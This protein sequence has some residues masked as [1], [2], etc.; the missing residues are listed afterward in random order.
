MSKVH[1]FTSKVGYYTNRSASRW[2]TRNTDGQIIWDVPDNPVMGVSYKGVTHGSDGHKPTAYSRSVI[3]ATGGS[4]EGSKANYGTFLKTNSFHGSG[5]AM[6][7]NPWGQYGISSGKVTPSGYLRE[8]AIVGA[9]EKMHGQNAF[10]LEDLAQSARTAK[11]VYDLAKD[12]VQKTGKYLAVLYAA[13]SFWES[14]HGPWSR[15]YTPKSAKRSNDPWLKRLANAWLA[16]YYGIKPLISTINAIGRNE[17][18]RTK[19]VKV[20][21]KRSAVLDP[22]GLF[23]QSNWG[24]YY[25]SFS[26]NAKEEVTVTLILDVSMSTNMGALAA[27]GWR[28]EVDPFSSPMSLGLNVSDGQALQ[29][30]WALVP[31]SFVVDW[32]IPVEKFLSTLTWSPGITYKGGFITNWM[33]GYCDCREK[34]YDPNWKGF[35]DKGR[36]EALLFQRE[37]YHDY[38]PPSALAV[39][40]GISP[41]QALNG[42]MLLISR[43][44]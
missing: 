8:K 20:R 33:G 13:I 35:K 16:W 1:S 12:I 28:T 5:L 17:K 24:G 26:G 29:L 41:T 4:G 18:P 25:Y 32:I 10:I 19:S 14:N 31:Y 40:Q 38:P 23:S 15:R 9:I 3:R 44:G 6:H 22:S 11:E 21:V 36:V 34:N 30:G 2:T 37:T 27:L 43:Y 7:Q 42:A 39:N